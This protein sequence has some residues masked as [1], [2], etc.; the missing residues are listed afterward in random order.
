M[1]L[2]ECRETSHRTKI[3]KGP[4][5]LLAQGMV[6]EPKRGFPEIGQMRKEN[7]DRRLLPTPRAGRHALIFIRNE[8]GPQFFVLEAEIL[9]MTRVKAKHLTAAGLTKQLCSQWIVS[10]HGHQRLPHFG[11]STIFDWNIG[12]PGVHGHDGVKCQHPFHRG[13]AHPKQA[14]HK[15]DCEQ[16]P[17]RGPPELRKSWKR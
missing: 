12:E 6:L 10:V 16:Q 4:R 13:I 5:L 11:P 17:S 7:G 2:G 14:V 3:F 9:R 15:G 8:L 1:L